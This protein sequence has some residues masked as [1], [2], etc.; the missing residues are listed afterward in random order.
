M[1]NKPKYNGKGNQ[2]ALEQDLALTKALLDRGE[3]DEAEELMEKMEKVAQMMAAEEDAEDDEDP[4]DDDNDNDGDEEDDGDE[5]DVSKSFREH[6]ITYP[7]DDL[8][9]AMTEHRQVDHPQ[10]VTHPTWHR[11]M[12]RARTIAARDA[13]PMTVAMQRA[14]GEM[15]ADH[16]AELRQP[17][18]AVKKFGLPKTPPLY[19]HGEAEE[20]LQDSGRKKKKTH[21]GQRHRRH[22]Q[23]VKSHEGAVADQVAKG[24]SLM[25]AKQIVQHTYGNTLPRSDIL[26]GAGDTLVTSFMAKCNQVMA[27][28]GCERTDAMR[29][30][31]KRHE[32]LFDA[33]QLV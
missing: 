17:V 20:L 16:V 8:T 4:E 18:S 10:V 19:P 9:D 24:H 6:N 22:D 13:C 5:D 28:E 31:R 1:A 32:G 7:R 11:F 2:M 15:G 33:F 26:K 30:V 27:E 25:V 29:I 14:R 21:M 12:E 23:Q 3:L